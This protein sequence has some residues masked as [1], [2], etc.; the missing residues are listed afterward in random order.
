MGGTEMFQTTDLHP[1]RA[2]LLAVAAFLALSCAGGASAQDTGAGVDLQF[3]DRLD[4][5][6]GQAQFG[7][8]PRGTSWLTAQTRRTPSGFLYLCPPQ[9][10]QLKAVDDW[11]YNATVSLGFISAADD[12][13]AQWQRYTGWE[14]A[15]TVG[16]LTVSAYRPDDGTYVQV[17][18]SR[19]NSDSQSLK[20][21]R[22]RAGHYKIDLFYRAQPNVVSGNAR[23]IWN[24][25][26]SSY[27]SLVDGLTPAS[28]TPAQVSAAPAAS[29]RATATSAAADPAMMARGERL[30]LQGDAARGIPPCQGCH[31]ADGRGHPEVTR[32]APA[33]RARVPARYRS[34]PALRGQQRDHLVVKL[35]EYH[36]GVLLDSTNDFIMNGVARNLD[37]DS[38]QA[39]ATWLS[40]RAVD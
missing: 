23:S 7:C 15:F 17:R 9:M 40:T 18:G 30:Y 6:G 21:T 4:P 3:G 14:D 8:D 1:I 20:V 38:I 29:P 33:P 27:L 5:T 19:L 10:S 26:G 34:Y 37:A 35:T 16:P 13:N 32:S 22:G 12:S 39:L 11:V 28:S 2:T 24:G 36:D 31:G 25:L